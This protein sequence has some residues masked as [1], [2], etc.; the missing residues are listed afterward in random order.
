MNPLN[1]LSWWIWFLVLTSGLTSCV[2]TKSAAFRNSFLPP[3]PKPPVPRFVTPEPPRLEPS[4]EWRNPPRVVVAPS[5]QILRPTRAES[6]IR[7]AD[8]H[9]QLG[10]KHY[11]EGDEAGARRELDRKSVV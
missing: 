5:Q 1:K 9:Y 8:W 2:S 11:Q 3:A 6:L 7:E 4:L 10:K